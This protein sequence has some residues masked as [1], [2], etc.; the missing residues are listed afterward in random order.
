MEVD[1]TVGENVYRS[2]LYVSGKLEGRTPNGTEI[3]GRRLRVG[4]VRKISR[5]LEPRSE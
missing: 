5:R 4:L 1:G 3:G 2:N